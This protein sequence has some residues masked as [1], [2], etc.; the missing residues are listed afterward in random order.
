MFTGCHKRGAVYGT[1]K[2]P[3]ADVVF[4]RHPELYDGYGGRQENGK[5]TLKQAGREKNG[6]EEAGRG[7]GRP[8]EERR[9]RDAG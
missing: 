8:E 4:F 6:D 2:L 1:E 7:N 9:R 3:F 5:G